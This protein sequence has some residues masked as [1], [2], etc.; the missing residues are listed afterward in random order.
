M[1]KI[2]ELRIRYPKVTAKP[3]EIFFNGD[4]TPTKKYLE[5]MFKYW[6]STPSGHR[7]TSN[8]VVALVNKFDSLLPY[9]ENKDIYSK[10]YTFI[11]QLKMVVEIAEKTKLDN[12]FVREDHID[13]LMEN[14]DFLL[15]RPKT[16]EGSNKYGANTRWCTTGKHIS[17]FTRYTGHSFLFYLVSKKET[18]KNRYNKIAFLIG[19]GNPLT[20]VIQIYN[21]VDDDISGEGAL[22]QNGWSSFEVFEIIY[23][24]RSFAYQMAFQEQVKKN[25]NGVIT[26]LESIDMD[27]FFKNIKIISNLDNVETD[28]KG[29]LE[30]ILENLKSKINF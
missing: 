3:A 30:T 4:K 21:Q 16:F 14:D 2:D 17:H 22:V 19:K 8:Q 29:K 15:L 5:Y 28:Y 1:A 18:K 27:E 25:I 7:M 6:V 20:T 23:K 9:I 26:K 11:S 12:E 10:E 24:C 13:V